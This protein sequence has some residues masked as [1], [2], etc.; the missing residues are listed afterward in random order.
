MLVLS[1]EY[2]SVSEAFNCRIGVDALVKILSE[3]GAIVLDALPDEVD[4]DA[5]I[6][7]LRISA[8]IEI[9]YRLCYFA[10]HPRKALKLI[11]KNI[12]N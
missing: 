3:W 5:V 2:G 10:A 9:A 12:N 1:R 6:S 8:H 7:L 4:K 11:G